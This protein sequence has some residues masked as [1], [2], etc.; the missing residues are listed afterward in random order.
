MS[1]KCRVVIRTLIKRVAGLPM[2]GMMR[3]VV[4]CGRMCVRRIDSA[5]TVAAAKAEQ[6]PGAK[7]Q[8][9]KEWYIEKEIVP[10]KKLDHPRYK[11]TLYVSLGKQP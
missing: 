8:A 5:M 7:E 11:H 3:G 2:M 4:P 6:H 9:A 10:S 1:E